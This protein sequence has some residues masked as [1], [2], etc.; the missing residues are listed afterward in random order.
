[1]EV[2]SFESACTFLG[3]HLTLRLDGA[4]IELLE[5]R[6]A[7]YRWRPGHPWADLSEPWLATR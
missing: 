3:H 4:S 7:I 5:R 2:P 6:R 1:L